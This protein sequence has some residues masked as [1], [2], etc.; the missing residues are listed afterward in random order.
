MPNRRRHEEDVCHRLGIPRQ[1][2]I[3][4]VQYALIFVVGICVGI[5][6]LIAYQGGK[7]EKNQLPVREDKSVNRMNVLGKKYG[8]DKVTH[9]EYDEIYPLFIE[10][11]YGSEGAMLEIGIQSEKS[12]KMCLEL[13][14]NAFIFG[15]DIGHGDKKGDRYHIIKADQS[16]QTE[17]DRLKEIIASRSVFFINDDGSHIPEH[18]LLTFNTLFPVL[19][20]N[21]VYIIEDVETSYWTKEGLYGYKTRYGYKHNDSILEIFKDVV[22]TVNQEFAGKRKNRV[23]V[24]HDSIGSITFSRN[25]II[26]VKKTKETRPYRFAERVDFP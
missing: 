4:N 12:L 11:Y 16:K 5:F 23:T 2:F 19:E 20:E 14:P 22:D 1:K 21:G 18:Q 17:L 8:T 13:F 9:H 6:C 25:C 24:D 7:I 3:Q 15:V 26:I 10:Q